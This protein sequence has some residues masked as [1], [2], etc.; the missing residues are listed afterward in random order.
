MAAQHE[1]TALYRTNP[2]PF[3]QTPKSNFRVR[4]KKANE[5]ALDGETEPFP[6]SRIDQCKQEA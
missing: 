3:S 5:K 2:S 1:K 4:A 6:R